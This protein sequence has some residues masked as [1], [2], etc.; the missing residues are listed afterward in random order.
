MGVG[1]FSEER[2]AQRHFSFYPDR[3]LEMRHATWIAQARE[4]WKEHLPKMYARLEKTGK[5]EQALTEA[6][7]AT[8][9][10]IRA[11]TTQGATWQ[12]AWEQVRETYLFPP[13]EPE[14]KPRMRKT[15]G[16]LAHRELMMG[17]SRI[18]MPDDDD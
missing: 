14:Q 18:G 7:E 4:H 10:G 6:A 16:Y 3:R 13:E 9:N 15:Q 17:L 1:Q 2:I 12:E 8:S 11:L 5:L